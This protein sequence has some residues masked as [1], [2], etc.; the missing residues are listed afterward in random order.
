MTPNGNLVAWQSTMT[1]CAGSSAG[2]R[3]TT[4]AKKVEWARALVIATSLIN[5]APSLTEDPEIRDM[6]VG[7]REWF[8]AAVGSPCSCAV[9]REWSCE[10]APAPWPTRGWDVRTIGLGTGQQGMW[11]LPSWDVRWRAGSQDGWTAEVTRVAVVEG[12]KNGCSKLPEIVKKDMDMDIVQAE[13]DK[14]PCDNPIDVVVEATAGWKQP[15]QEADM[16]NRTIDIY[17]Y[18]DDLIGV[19]GALTTVDEKGN[20]MGG[21]FDA[22]GGNNDVVGYL[23]IAKR[24]RVACIYNGVWSFAPGGHLDGPATTKVCRWI[25]ISVSRST[26]G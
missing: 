3:K 21:E 25:G 24:V 2:C 8:A 11:A 4:T 15:K 23:E 7:I 16:A 6:L 1:R 5:V 26:H 14:H 13:Y 9:A 19:E 22:Y 17:G 18:S 12:V 10:R 20:G